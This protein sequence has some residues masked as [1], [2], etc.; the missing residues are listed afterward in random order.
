MSDSSQELLTFLQRNEIE[1]AKSEQLTEEEVKLFGKQSFNY[2]QMRVLRSLLKSDLEFEAVERIAKPWI[3]ASDMEELAEAMRNGEEVTIP[4]RPHSIPITILGALAVIVIGMAV[5]FLTY[6]ERNT[7]SL[8]LAAD[9]IRLSCGMKFEPASYVK[10]SHGENARLILPEEFTADH[11]EVRLVRY[12]LVSDE[13]TVS[14]LLRITVV[15]ETPPEITLAQEHVEL[16]RVTPFSCQAYLIKAMDNVD[17][18][19]SRQVE[20]S[21][22]LTDEE[23]QTVEYAVA[24]HSGNRSVET[25]EVHFAEEPDSKQEEPLL[26]LSPPKPH[27][28]PTAA[29]QPIPTPQPPAPTYEEAQIIE[30]AETVTESQEI[31]SSETVVE[32]SIE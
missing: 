10:E 31:V 26:A 23:T 25:L 7:L 11:P 2:L 4:K 3:S 6:P 20:C 5:L 27:V 8:E 1:Q 16:L 17:G 9:E 19:L 32:H 18:D 30:Y 28:V 22:S 14:K 29:P 13:G 21:D 15:D 12:E 24:D